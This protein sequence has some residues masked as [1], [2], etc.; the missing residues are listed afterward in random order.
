LKLSGQELQQA[1]LYSYGNQGLKDFDIYQGLYCDNCE[2]PGANFGRKLLK[3]QEV[4]Y[5]MICTLDLA[6]KQVL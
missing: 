1:P 2:I 5:I 3:A 6:F 4:R